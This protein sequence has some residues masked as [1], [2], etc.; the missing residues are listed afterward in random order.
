MDLL[1]ARRARTESVAQALSAPHAWQRTDTVG[2]E[3]VFSC[4]VSADGAAIITGPLA[5]TSQWRAD[6]EETG[7]VRRLTATCRGARWSR[8]IRLSRDGGEWSCRTEETGDAPTGLPAPGI[9]DPLRL[10]PDAVLHLEDS[11]VSA[12][13]TLRR[14][15]LTPASGPV[16]VPTVRVLVPSLVVLPGVSTFH[17][18][19]TRRLRVTGDEP[20]YTCE[21]DD[22][23]IVTR[24]PGRFRLVY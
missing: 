18:I 15:A 1:V 8:T 12:G 23:G 2:T 17:M 5:Y 3:L 13:W 6:L 16:T 22:A 14:L 11:P 9:D 4:P 24:R 19:S 10:Q 21:L 7:A 20:A